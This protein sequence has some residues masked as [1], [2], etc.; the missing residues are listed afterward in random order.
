MEDV[1]DV[2]TRPYDPRRPQVCLDETSRQLLAEARPPRPPLPGRPARQDYEY[3][4]EGV[5]NLFLL[6]E[7]VRG[8]RHVTVSDRRTRLDYA[9]C[10]KDLVDV[11]YPDAEVIVLVQDDLNTHTPAALY[12]AFA[13][14]EAKRLADKLEVH[15]T[16]KHG[17]WLN[18]AEIE[19]SVLAEQCL[20]R[21]IA[22]R[23]TLAREVA[24]WEARRN[25]ATKTIDWRFTTADARI[26]LTQL[27]PAIHE[28]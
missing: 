25:A 15:Y 13:P 1:L 8:R 9:A 27:Y 21:R 2:Y 18:M 7:P 10:I 14:A 26:K 12:E 5:V 6:C 20:D 3:A 11:Q 19:L 28:C 17:S 4:R 22:D 23:A 24:A 16:P